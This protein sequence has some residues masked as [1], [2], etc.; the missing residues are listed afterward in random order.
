MSSAHVTSEKLPVRAGKKPRTPSTSPHHQM[1]QNAPPAMQEALYARMRTLA[2]VVEGPSNVSV[3]GTRAFHLDPR[4]GGGPR[5]AFMVG[6][7]FAHLHPPYDGS[8]H[9]ALPHGLLEEVM[10]KGWG[11][12]HPVAG[13]FGV[14]D[15]ATMVYGPRDEEELEVVWGLVRASH[16]YARGGLG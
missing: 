5:E 12:P 1:D 13:K 6:R 8:L 11:T 3:P 2:G 7:E 10:E 14:P 15:T 4:E 16:E 9:L